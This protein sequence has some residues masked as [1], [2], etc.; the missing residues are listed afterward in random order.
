[1][2]L[3]LAG[4]GDALVSGL[5]RR[6][7]SAA[8]RVMPRS[9]FMSTRP[10][11]VC[12]PCLAVNCN[13]KPVLCL[14]S[15]GTAACIHVYPEFPDGVEGP[16]AM[17]AGVVG[18]TGDFNFGR[19]CPGESCLAGLPDEFLDVSRLVC[20]CMAALAKAGMSM[21]QL[22]AYWRSRAEYSSRSAAGRE[23]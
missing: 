2:G 1:M 9:L 19:S 12:V 3:G 16:G 7:R 18:L 4:A 13:A 22:E 15:V 6:M 23:M 20:T 8:V 17:V 21:S 10:A 14:C 5:A 11:L